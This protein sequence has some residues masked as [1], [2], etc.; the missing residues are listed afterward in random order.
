MHAYM[1]KALKWKQ[2]DGA[3]DRKQTISSSDFSTWLKE[4]E[5]IMKTSYREKFELK[6]C[7]R[8]LAEAE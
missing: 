1:Q 7:E 5:I 4:R 3:I 6:L 8:S 2:N